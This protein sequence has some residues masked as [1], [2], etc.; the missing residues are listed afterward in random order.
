MAVLGPA[1]MD[2][3][4]LGDAFEFVRVEVSATQSATLGCGTSRFT[5]SG[6]VVAARVAATTAANSSAVR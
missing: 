4:V 5:P 2:L 6:P 1:D 3:V